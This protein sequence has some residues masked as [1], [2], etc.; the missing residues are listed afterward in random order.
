MSCLDKLK[1]AP[2]LS[3]ID[4]LTKQ[5]VPSIIG[6]LPTPQ[7]IAIA[8]K[9]VAA[10]TK[11]IAEQV[12][13]EINNTINAVTGKIS[14]TANAVKGIG[15]AL[16]SIEQRFVNS[17][18]K[19]A[20]T[21]NQQAKAVSD[22]LDC[23]INAMKENSTAD[24]EASELQTG[25]TAAATAAGGALTNNQIKEFAENP[26][27][28]AQFIAAKTEEV[29]AKTI[30]N[31]ATTPSNAQIN[32]KQQQAVNKLETATAPK[33]EDDIIYGIPKSRLETDKTWTRLARY[34]WLSSGIFS[35]SSRRKVL[36]NYGENGKQAIQVI[37]EELNFLRESKDIYPQWPWQRKLLFDIYE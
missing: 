30:K 12:A 31:V 8:A 36:V 4:K 23:E 15:T 10:L 25:V 29:K 7:K 1:N 37:E 20:E 21:L 34:N 33:E 35:L 11:N 2:G 14:A 27:K 6:V 5:M 13:T 28:K 17:V 26:L 24:F 22:F 32:Q 3:S 19:V 16:K 18:K 9:N